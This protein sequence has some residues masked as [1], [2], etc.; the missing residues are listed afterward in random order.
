MT[1]W[2]KSVRKIATMPGVVWTPEVVLARTLEKA[3]AH[4]D[5]AEFCKSAKVTSVYIG[6]QFSDGTYGYDYSRMSIEQLNMHHLIIEMRLNEL[7]RE[8]F[9]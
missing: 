1:E 7:V 5:A 8:N 9:Q 4:I 3:R 6:V 2:W